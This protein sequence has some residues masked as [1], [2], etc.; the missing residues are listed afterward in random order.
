MGY[1]VRTSEFGKMSEK[2]KAR[3]VSE[4]ARRAFE[5]NGQAG[6]IDARIDEFERRYGFDSRQ[7]L[8]A[9]TEGRLSETDEIADW[10]WLL[11]FRSNRVS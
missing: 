7:L 8:Q 9:L 10:L 1:S 11:N 2:D 5:S 4:L 3:A 6:Q